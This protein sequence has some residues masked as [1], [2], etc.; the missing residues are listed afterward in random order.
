MFQ[1]IARTNPE[2]RSLGLKTEPVATVPG[3]CARTLHTVAV[4]ASRLQGL[5]VAATPKVYSPI[6]SGTK[7]VLI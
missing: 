1:E 5:L 7:G 3:P 6:L 2:H 4:H